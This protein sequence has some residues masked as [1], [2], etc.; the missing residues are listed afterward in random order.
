MSRQ[1]KN[2]RRLITIVTRNSRLMRPGFTLVE[3]LVVIAVIGLL[4]AVLMPA[5]SG[6]RRKALAISCSSRMRQVG[7]SSMMYAQDNEGQFA[8]SSHSASI[9][10][11]L[12]WERAF[13]P[14]LG[15]GQ[16]KGLKTPDGLPNPTWMAILTKFYHCPADS[17][18][19]IKLAYGKNVWFEMEPFDLEQLG[20]PP[21]SYRTITQVRHPAATVEFGELFEGMGDHFMAENWIG[22][23][24][25]QGFIPVEVDA[26]RHGR[27]ANY[28]YLDGHVS[29]QEFKETFDYSNPN[30]VVDNWNP[31]TARQ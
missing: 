27:V 22:P 6:A 29:P 2:M 11:W 19:P 17:R 3:L 15:Y 25:P 21:A 26:K 10:G 13:M 28:S 31:G 18:K 7:A 8:R 12:Q 1:P 4:L 23:S 14:Y 5:L 30:M 9:Y 24:S 20:L 16:F